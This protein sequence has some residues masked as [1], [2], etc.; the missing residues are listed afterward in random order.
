MTEHDH[1]KLQSRLELLEEITASLETFKVNSTLWQSQ[2]VARSQELS[3][4]IQEINEVRLPKHE[5]DIIRNRDE[6][7]RLDT[8]LNL[9]EEEVNM[10]FSS[11][12]DNFALS[13]DARKHDALELKEL[14][15]DVELQDSNIK[16]MGAKIERKLDNSERRH[17]EVARDFYSLKRKC[18]D[19]ESDG[20]LSSSKINRVHSMLPTVHERRS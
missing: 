4:Q 7:Y 17:L 20:R 6:V 18:V 12:D 15:A 16:L 3:A 9:F 1:K 2:S 10:K 13:E 14:A 8:R 5:T 11:Y 19:L